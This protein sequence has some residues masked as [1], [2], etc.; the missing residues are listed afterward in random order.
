MSGLFHSIIWYVQKLY[1]AAFQSSK[2]AQGCQGRKAVCLFRASFSASLIASSS[3]LVVLLYLVYVGCRECRGFQK[4]SYR[5]KIR[6]LSDFSVISYIPS[7]IPTFLEAIL[8]LS[9]RRR[10]WRSR[11]R[12]GGEEL[13]A[14]RG[15]GWRM[16]IRALMAMV[17]EEAGWDGFSPLC[18]VFYEGST[19]ASSDGCRATL[20]SPRATSKARDRI[21]SIF[22]LDCGST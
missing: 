11:R 20:S 16:A 21:A 1:Q 7:Y 14:S 2:S 4:D 6:E 5:E 10:R 12:T 3:T 15:G 22:F 8:F 17:A 9:R 13:E 18:V 19:W